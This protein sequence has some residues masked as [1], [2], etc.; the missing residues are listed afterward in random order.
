MAS[1]R[2]YSGE[3]TPGTDGELLEGFAGDTAVDEE[4]RCYK[5]DVAAL[6]PRNCDFR[7][8]EL[9]AAEPAKATLGAGDADGDGRESPAFSLKA[10]TGRKKKEWVEMQI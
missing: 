2:S 8:Q 1:R 3:E 7:R 4:R 10:L 5:L 9:L 6:L